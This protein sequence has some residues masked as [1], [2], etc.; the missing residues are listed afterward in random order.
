M[1]DCNTLLSHVCQQDLYI[2]LYVCVGILFVLLQFLED[3][4]LPI[5]TLEWLIFVQ[6]NTSYC[7]MYMY[8]YLLL[9][10]HN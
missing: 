2:N 6:V 3:V 4:L 9:Q 10:L 8:V 5:L 1:Y 7:Y